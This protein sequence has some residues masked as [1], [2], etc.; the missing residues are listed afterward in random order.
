L[1]HSFETGSLAARHN[2]S[3]HFEKGSHHDGVMKMSAVH[4][5]H[6]TL[7]D[8]LPDWLARTDAG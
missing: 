2:R 5:R 1:G 6:E 4:F 3:L 7:A 8:I